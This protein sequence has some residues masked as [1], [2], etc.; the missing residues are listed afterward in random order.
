MIKSSAKVWR[1]GAVNEDLQKRVKDLI[2]KLKSI[3]KLPMLPKAFKSVLRCAARVR[4]WPWRVDPE[5]DEALT[6]QELHKRILLTV[7]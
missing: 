2:P 4:A 3:R 6:F 5:D 7:L 1:L